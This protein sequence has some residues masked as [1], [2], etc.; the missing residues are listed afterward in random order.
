M[1]QVSHNALGGVPMHGNRKMLTEVLR[2][3]LGLGDTGYVGSDEGN[4]FQLSVGYVCGV[5]VC[6]CVSVLVC[7]SAGVCLLRYHA[8]LVDYRSGSVQIQDL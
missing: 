3:R 6:V 7:V 4:V 8:Y 1:P 2:H 5:C